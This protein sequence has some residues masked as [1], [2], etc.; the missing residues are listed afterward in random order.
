MLAVCVSRL[1]VLA[2]PFVVYFMAISVTPLVEILSPSMPLAT[3][4]PIVPFTCSLLIGAVVPMPTSPLFVIVITVE[5][6]KSPPAEVWKARLFPFSAFIFAVAPR[7][8]SAPE[9]EAEPATSNIA[10][11][12]VVPIPTY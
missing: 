1:P 6:P 5:R 4:D 10:V 9:T 12:A 11:G 3:S 2:T 7:N 8:V